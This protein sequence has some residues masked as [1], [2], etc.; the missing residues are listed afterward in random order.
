MT[1]NPVTALE[2]SPVREL[3]GWMARDE[4]GHIPIV[5]DGKVGCAVTK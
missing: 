2:T 3:A 4:I 1:S 5:R